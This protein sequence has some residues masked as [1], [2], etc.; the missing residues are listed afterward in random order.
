MR[1]TLKATTLKKYL[2]KI[3]RVFDIDRILHKEITKEYVAEYYLKS[4]LWFRMFHSIK[5][6]IHMA[7]NFDG[8]FNK[9]G[10]YEQATIINKEIGK[11]DT[12]RVLEIGSARGFNTSYLSR[13]NPNIQFVGIDLSAVFVSQAQKTTKKLTNVA[14]HVGDFQAL[15]F[16]SLFF[17]LVFEVES[18]C[19]ALNMTAVLSEVYRVLKPGG[20]F[21]LF[22]GFRKH[23]FAESDS[24]LKRAS[25]LVELSM[26]VVKGWSI[27]EV[28]KI[29][30]EV[31]F[32]KIK[33]MDISE[34]IMPN[35]A[36][37]QFLGRGYFKYPW[38]AKAILWKWSP[39]TVMNSIAGLLMPFTLTA[40]I[41]G[42]FLVVLERPI[43]PDIGE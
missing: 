31:G 36:K 13:K 20:R 30:S 14:F 27:D 43:E 22:D 6:S 19:H 21:I 5:G 37:F 26:A 10:Y 29:A 32:K 41:Q 40:G 16:E 38:L 33:A 18:I 34:A 2:T 7:L 28:L 35:L 25:R 12:H 11:L 8:I 3:S 4:G 9:S 24:D 39:L 17:N 1:K 23:G 15:E 42:Y